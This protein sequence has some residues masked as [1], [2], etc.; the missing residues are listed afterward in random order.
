MQKMILDLDTGI[1][2]AQA[3]AYAV[4][5][6]EIELIGIIGSYGNVQAAEAVQNSIN[7]LEI[8][9][10][11]EIP[12]FQGESHP[13]GADGF[14][15]FEISRVIHGKD[16]IGGLC[17]ENSEKRARKQSGVEFLTEAAEK[18]AE[19]LVIVSTGPMTDL[20]AAIKKGRLKGFKGRIVLM[21]GAVTV[22]GNCGPFAEANMS[23]DAEAAALLFDSGL[24]ITMV[25]LDVTLR[26]LFTKE[27][28]SIWRNIGT[29][30]AKAYAD[31][32][33]YYID[34]YAVTSPHLKGCALHDPLA[35]AAAIDPKLIK[36]HSMYLKVY[37]D[38][39]REDYGR[40][41][42]DPEKLSM[43][44]PNVKVAIDV[45]AERFIDLFTDRL[46]SLFE[47]CN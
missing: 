40:T 46:S 30:A 10:Y 13:L 42:G 23:Q 19:N 26:T 41:T 47:K 12:V 35:V 14:E 33:D 45:D 8:L 2:D 43:P 39:E 5:S 21:G 32:T 27:Q 6:P 3:I 16:G 31:M 38:I 24:D 34:A 17:L 25:G 44:D 20:G 28:T 36:T 18:Y 11:R 9:G 1:D 37:Q 7:L 29:K 22:P 4:A 15:V